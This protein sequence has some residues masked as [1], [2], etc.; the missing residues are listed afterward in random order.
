[1]DCRLNKCRWLLVV[2]LALSLLCGS[3]NAEGEKTGKGEFGVKFGHLGGGTVE[4]QLKS[5]ESKLDTVKTGSSYSGGAFIS[6]SIWGGLHGT[7][8]FDLHY[9]RSEG[10][11][12]ET[13]LDVAGG[14]KY[15]LTNKTRFVS[16]RPA[17]LVGF[18]I[19]PDIWSFKSSQYMTLKLVIELAFLTQKG[20]GLLIE[21]G[22]LQTLSGGDAKYDIE[23][24]S[25]MLVRG[26]LIL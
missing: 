12:G 10:G 22:N 25:M 3:A 5:G 13:A 11:S 15:V 23:A 26:G 20:T 6:Q 9:L 19:L 16:I 17:A 14:L 1:M 24:K 2:C 7:V 4:Y 8:T 18:A 21:I